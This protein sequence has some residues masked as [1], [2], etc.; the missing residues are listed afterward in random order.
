MSSG[1]E[2]WKWNDGSFFY[3]E[4]KYG[5]WKFNYEAVVDGRYLAWGYGRPDSNQNCLVM[6]GS[7]QWRWEDGDCAS[8]RGYICQGQL[9]G[10]P[11]IFDVNVVECSSNISIKWT[12]S[13][14]ALGVTH[15][16]IFVIVVFK[17]EKANSTT[18]ESAEDLQNIKGKTLKNNEAFIALAISRV[19]DDVYYVTLH[20]KLVRKKMLIDDLNMQELQDNVN[21]DPLYAN[22][23][24]DKMKPRS[25]YDIPL[26]QLFERYNRLNEKDGAK[27]K[28]E[29]QNLKSDAKGLNYPTTIASSESLNGKNRYKNILPCDLSRVLLDGEGNMSYINACYINGFCKAKKF[30]A[31]Q[32]PLPSTVNDFWR[33][34]VEQKVSCIVMLTKFVENGK[35]K[36]EKYWPSQGSPKQ[37]GDVYVENR[38]EIFTGCYK[39]FT[40]TIT[41][42]DEQGIKVILL[43]YLNWPDYGVPVTTTNLM[44]FHGIVKKHQS[45]A[46]IVVHC[47]AGAGRTGAFIALDFLLQESESLRS[48]D[49][50]NCILKLREQRVDMVQTCDQYI[51]VHKLILENYLFGKTDMESEKFNSV[52]TRVSLDIGILQKQ[53][54]DLA[55][56]GPVNKTKQ[57]QLA[58]Q[59]EMNRNKEVIPFSRNNIVIVRN[60][61]EAETPCLNASKV[62]VRNI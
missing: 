51:M 4:T 55:K 27:F 16:C 22:I 19:I 30:I 37:F 50:Y 17:P 3:N 46:P 40:L 47:S 52:F 15:S 61:T 39:M 48:V 25:P 57:G 20:R 31:T 38:D 59:P 32:G 34:I 2:I 45:N 42:K 36:C 33:M 14:N 41:K 7:L 21:D 58:K 1:L 8:F 10:I 44:R 29:F 18:F 24:V 5:N 23:A 56:V 12:P 53:F 13:S 28:G 43:Q 9:A 35:K 49:V 54:N 26:E 11:M 62:E 6:S 60:P